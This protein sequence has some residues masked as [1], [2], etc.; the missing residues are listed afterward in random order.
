MSKTPWLTPD[1]MELWR[2]YMRVQKA[3]TARLNRQL[4]RD[5]GLSL[6]D[7]D[8]LVALSADDSGSQ[9]I[10]ALASTLGWE[11]S[12]LS[13]HAARMHRRGLIS[14]GEVA[15]DGRGAT[16]ELTEHGWEVTRAAAPGHV[17]EVR[18]LFLD[19]LLAGDVPRLTEAL[20]RVA[21]VVES[22]S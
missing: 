14:R 13:H 17:E 9:R 18:R 11:R 1:E 15:G 12:R 3:L 22:G 8:V 19:P 4:Q 6:T 21:T 7:W 5:S 16:L 2:T 10:T 20:A